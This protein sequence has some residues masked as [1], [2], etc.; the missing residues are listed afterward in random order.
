[1]VNKSVVYKLQY[2]VHSEQI[3]I[4]YVFLRNTSTEVKYTFQAPPCTGI[5]PFFQYWYFAKNT[6]VIKGLKQIQR[7]YIYIYNCNSKGMATFNFH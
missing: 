7:S 2:N 5:Q 4:T 6:Y 3:F 1:M